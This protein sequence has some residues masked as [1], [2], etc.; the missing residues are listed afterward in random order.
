MLRNLIVLPDGTELFSGTSGEN[1]LQSV[2]LTQQ[3]N[4]GAELTLGSVC[5]NMLEA[6]LIT[7]AGGLT[8]QPGMELTLYKVS[9]DGTR[10]QVG[11]FIAEKPTRPGANSYKI[12]AYDRVSRLDR[13]LSDW[14]ES[15]NG[16]P[17]GVLEFANMVCAACNLTLVNQTLPNGTWQIPRFSARGITGRQLIRWVGELSGRFCRATVTGELEF[18]WYT[19][20]DIT[21]S[22]EGELPV[23]SGKLEDYTTAPIDKVQLRLTEKDIGVIWGDGSNCCCITGNYLLTADTPE[24]LQMVAQE[25]YATLQSVQYTPCSLKIPA[26]TAIWPGDILSVTDQN[27]RTVTVY[28]MKKVQTGPVETLECKGSPYRDSVTATN[29]ATFTALSGSVLELQM[30]VE[31]LRAENRNG[32]GRTAAL[33]MTV[34]GLKT[35]IIHQTA[36][37]TDITTRMSAAEQTAEGLSLEVQTVKTQGVSRVSTATGYTFDEVGLT[38]E[39]SGRE[40]KTRITEDGMQV[41]KNEEAVL[42]ANSEGVDAVD[43]HASTYLA[44]GGRSRF[45]NYGANRTGCFWIGG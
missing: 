21:L 15:L 39:K 43:L 12:T 38:V 8:I 4:A 11:L 20:K 23:L 40:I 22:P 17:Y 35:E 24:A 14:L 28:V 7:P 29:S 41:F 13:D 9:D 18:A 32:Q 16:W 42:T 25:L 19:P 30:R 36:D 3:V 44:V 1:A 27:G 37:L 34:E 31:G 33:E 10:T 5:A 45:E 6:T 2:T 26:N